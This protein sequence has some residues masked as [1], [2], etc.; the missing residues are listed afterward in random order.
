MM[1]AVAH[2]PL[3][4]EGTPLHALPGVQVLDTCLAHGLPVAGY[5]GGG[6][7]RDLQ[8]LARRHTLLH[9]AADELWHSRSL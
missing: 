3:D 4:P 1:R 7:H 8:L 9:R 5:V 2:Y 6:Y